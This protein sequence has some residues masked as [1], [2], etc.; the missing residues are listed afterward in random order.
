[1]KKLLFSGLFSFLPVSLLFFAD[2]QGALRPNP[3]GYPPYDPYYARR[4]RGLNLKEIR[5]Q[6]AHRDLV[7]ARTLMETVRQALEDARAELVQAQAIDNNADAIAQAQAAV[8][9]AQAR[10]AVLQAQYQNALQTY[11]HE[12]HVGYGQ[13]IA[14]GIAGK[15]YEVV[16]DADVTSLADGIGKGL[17]VKTA[18]AVGDVFDEKIRGTI[19]HIFGGTWDIALGTVLDAW[20]S[21]CS[22]LFHDSCEPFNDLELSEWHTI[23]L[24]SI[25]DLEKAVSNSLRESTRGQDMTPRAKS[26]MQAG[27]SSAQDELAETP[28]QVFVATYAEQFLY[29]I[30]Q[31][32]LRKDYYSEKHHAHFYIDQIKKR[33]LGFIEILNAKTVKE[34]DAK[35][36]SNRYMLT[37]IKKNI[38]NLFKRLISDVK[39]RS[40]SVTKDAVNQ[41]KTSN[42]SK[43]NYSSA[44]DD[45]GF[46]MSHQ[47][48]YY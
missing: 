27:D 33:L 38:D 40:Y 29:F 47:N 24:A 16:V 19:N 25:E 31:L 32:E 30:E 36:D 35:L 48:A 17:C 42:S 14:R 5:A 15:D 13:L 45:M 8:V 23:I 43:N 7:A 3:F 1:M 4:D 37:A 6:D 39:P 18:R 44:N 26:L 20:N 34:V 12:T 46:P 10:H 11:A 28:W 41:S 9:A 2:L 22:Y 21:L